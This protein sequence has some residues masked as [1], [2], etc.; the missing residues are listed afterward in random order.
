MSV[1]LF[2]VSHHPHPGPDP[3]MTE[4]EGCVCVW[5]TQA[6]QEGREGDEGGGK[7]HER[8][9]WSSGLL[10]V[11]VLGGSGLPLLLHVFL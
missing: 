10:C 1:S 2:I 11:L 8:G 9:G 5:G 7:P 3:R 6:G 4:A